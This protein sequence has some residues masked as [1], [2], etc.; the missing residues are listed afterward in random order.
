MGD[1]NA[2]EKT[3][4]LVYYKKGSGAKNKNTTESH[5]R[6]T[7]I[8]V[9]IFQRISE[10]VLCSVKKSLIIGEKQ[11]VLTVFITQKN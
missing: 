11:E 3:F 2:L 4:G 1:S 5:M 10:S 9:F 6:A 8:I 7:Q